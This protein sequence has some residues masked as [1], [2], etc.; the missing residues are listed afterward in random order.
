MPYCYG[1]RSN[2]SIVRSEFSDPYPTRKEAEKAAFNDLIEYSESVS[3]FQAEIYVSQVDNMGK[4]L[5]NDVVIFRLSKHA[6]SAIPDPS[7]NDNS[8]RIN[9]TDQS[10]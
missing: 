5:V 2:N 10:S 7:Q 8:I 3:N 4:T 9:L 6:G 1:I